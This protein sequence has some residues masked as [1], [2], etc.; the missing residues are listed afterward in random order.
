AAAGVK[1]DAADALFE[2]MRA[3]SLPELRERFG[4]SAEVTAR[5]DDFE[6]YF[7]YLG[8]LGVREWV[9]LDL[10]IVRGLAYYT[11]IV[12]ELFDARGRRGAGNCRAHGGSTENARDAAA[13]CS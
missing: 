7:D 12:F 1:L 4:S 8:R 2:I 9:T 10:T 6:R 13:G 11:G 5:L 3:T